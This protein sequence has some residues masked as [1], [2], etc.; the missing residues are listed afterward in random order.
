M[1]PVKRP[2][3][4][5]T[6]FVMDL[7]FG[8]GWLGAAVSIA[9]FG[10]DGFSWIV[11]GIAGILSGVCFAGAVGLLRYRPMGRGLNILLGFLSLIFF[12]WARFSGR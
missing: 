8:V 3:G 11:A 1:N 9:A 10:R 5:S 12:P 7:L 4:V 2:L 6:L